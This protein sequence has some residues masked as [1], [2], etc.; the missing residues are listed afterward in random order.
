MAKISIKKYNE[1]VRRLSA[2]GFTP[3]TQ[4]AVLSTIYA[5]IVIPPE[6]KRGGELMTYKEAVAFLYKRFPEYK[7]RYSYQEYQTELKNLYKE[8]R[9]ERTYRSFMN[10]KR[11]QYQRT[12]DEAFGKGYMDIDEYSTEYLRDILNEAWR[13]AKNDP[14][15]SSSFSEY[16]HQLLLE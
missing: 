2:E 1:L 15:G 14:D 11:K 5:R 10:T 4:G 8:L 7:G 6:L 9:G 12:V 13:Q 3:R 16:L